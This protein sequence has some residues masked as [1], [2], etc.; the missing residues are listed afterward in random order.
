[1]AK[2]LF[3]FILMIHTQTFASG[4]VVCSVDDSQ[5]SFELSGGLSH[6][7]PGRP[8]NVKGRLEFRDSVLNELSMG[9]IE[10]VAEFWN[11]NGELKFS[12]YNEDYPGD[13]KSV[14]LSVEVKHDEAS[15]SYI[16]YYQ[17]RT[18][19]KTGVQT[20]SGPISCSQE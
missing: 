1:M 18:S 8:F 9:A 3:Y 6:G 4:G 17:V 5:I 14:D 11:R 2:L 10:D 12:I 13:F 7:M 20:L 19:L 16:G 15:E